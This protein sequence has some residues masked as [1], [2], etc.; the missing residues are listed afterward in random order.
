MASSQVEICVQFS[1]AENIKVIMEINDLMT[2][3]APRFRF[4]FI[5]ISLSGIMT[6][7]QSVETITLEL[8]PKINAA[9]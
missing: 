4:Y 2:T 7:F 1:Q 8:N 6:H 9:F 3:K 5:P